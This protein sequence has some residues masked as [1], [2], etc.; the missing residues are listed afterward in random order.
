MKTS[1]L[2]APTL[3]ALSQAAEVTL[4]SGRDCNPDDQIGYIQVPDESG[5]I[6]E[7]KFDDVKP[8]SMLVTG[9]AVVLL[10]NPDIGDCAYCANYYTLTGNTIKDDCI[11]DDRQ[12]CVNIETGWGPNKAKMLAVGDP[13]P[14]DEP[15]RNH[16]YRC[17]FPYP[18]NGFCAQA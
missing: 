3:L 7:Q 14:A 4:Y 15:C 1:L 10:S 17:D 11:V 9:Y 18:Y 5:N 12:K 16:Q 8:V 13:N 6:D 2:I